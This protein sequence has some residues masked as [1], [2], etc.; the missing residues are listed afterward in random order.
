MKSKVPLCGTLIN[1]PVSHRRKD[2]APFGEPRP[3]RDVATQRE[4]AAQERTHGRGRFVMH[5][6]HQ[7]C[8]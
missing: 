1:L 5:R 6:T 2:K 7:C 8:P 4:L 3:F